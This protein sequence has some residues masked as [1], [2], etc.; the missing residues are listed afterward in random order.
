MLNIAI[1]GTFMVE[2][3][4]APLSDALKELDASFRI[5]VVYSTDLVHHIQGPSGV[6][7]G[8]TEGLN[9]VLLR[10]EDWN[11]F[12][13]PQESEKETLPQLYTLVE[14]RMGGFCEVLE[15]AVERSTTPYLVCLCPVSSR[16]TAKGHLA[17]F[18][19]RMTEGL[20]ARLNDLPGVY[21]IQAK[22]P[23][24]GVA[25]ISTGRNDDSS[26]VAPYPDTF[27]TSLSQDI[28]RCIQR[29]LEDRTLG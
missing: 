7:A 24:E 9:V 25:D 18:F 23:P 14:R 22:A 3:L 10:F 2:A 26:E 13:D 5:R 29:L 12:E 4:Q 6:L 1:I 19:Q 8:N 27:F 16:V 28:A 21:L 11:N 17:A 20:I 15:C